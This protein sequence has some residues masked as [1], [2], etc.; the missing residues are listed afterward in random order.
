M[1]ERVYAAKNLS[2][3]F[4]GRIEST[5]F[6]SEIVE[7]ASEEFHIKPS[8]V[9]LRSYREAQDAP[10]PYAVFSLIYLRGLNS[11]AA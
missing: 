10:T 2:K 3:L 8:L 9:E 11:E 7:T 4:W 1:F 6:A 5:K